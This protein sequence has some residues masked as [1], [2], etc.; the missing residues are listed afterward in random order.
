MKKYSDLLKENQQDSLQADT[1]I[2]VDVQKEFQKFIPKDF[3]KK[4]NLYCKQF[5]EVIQIWDSN[6][7]DK[8]TWKFDNQTEFV[9]K[10]YGTKFSNDLVKVTDKLS[11]D[12]PN[13]KEGDVFKVS[14][15]YVVRIDN[16]HKWFYLN[17]DLQDLYRE[18]KGK[19]VIVVGGADNECIE[20][21]YISMRSF[22]INAIYNHEYIYSAQTS[23]KQQATI[24]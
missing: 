24:K 20:D 9:R 12:Y 16:N 3:E 17:D 2:I 22:G 6:K 15:D 1:L 5:K 8:P 21:I 18:L 11:V 13:S 4:L 23:N 10:N 14:G 7:T 19:K